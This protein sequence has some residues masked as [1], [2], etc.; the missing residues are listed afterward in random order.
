M[1]E[2][3]TAKLRV[4]AEQRLVSVQEAANALMQKKAEV[5]AKI[6]ELSAEFQAGVEVIQAYDAELAQAAT[7]EDPDS[8]E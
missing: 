6:A 4:L 2:E 3:T 1:N 8:E 5:E 7:P